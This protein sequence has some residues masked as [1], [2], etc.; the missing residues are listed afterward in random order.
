[1]N[2]R[3]GILISGRGSNL[4]AIIDAIQAG[5]LDAEVGVVISNCT[6]APGLERARRAGVLS[7][8]LDDRGYDDRSAYDRALTHEL[9]AHD[10]ALVCLAGFM[11]IVG[12][13]L[14]RAFP[15]AVLNIHPSLLPSFPGLEPQR[16]ACEHGVKVSGATVHVVTAELDAGPIVLQAAV[17]VLG[18]DTP[19]TL[20][21]R[22]LLEE[23]RLYPE[24]IALMLDGR[25]RLERRR[26]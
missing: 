21:S 3:L 4:Q 17:P 13:E 20:A 2:R 7:K 15:N 26:C 11:K 22:I 12:P 24:A 14:L 1:M 25:F 10:V 16:Q 9:R 6:E 8:V 23:H 5:R 19:E 18:D